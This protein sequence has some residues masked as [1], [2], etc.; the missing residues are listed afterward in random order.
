MKLCI[1]NQ[2]RTLILLER[3]MQVGHEFDDMLKWC[4]LTRRVMHA[5]VEMTSLKAKQIVTAGVILHQCLVIDGYLAMQTHSA[6]SVV[7]NQ[8]VMYILSS[9]MVPTIEIAESRLLSV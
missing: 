4:S 3:H 7:F 8:R 5:V 2:F 9:C 1:W 6:D